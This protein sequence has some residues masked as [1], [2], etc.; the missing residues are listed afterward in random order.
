MRERDV[1]VLHH[2]RKVVGRAFLPEAGKFP[3]VIFSHG[4]NGSGDDFLV[5]ARL[6]AGRGIGAV[7]YDFC[8]GS[9]C[10]KS[11]L[12]SEEMTIFSEKEDLLAVLDE[13]RSW[14][15]VDGKNVFLF[16]AS[17]GGLVTALAAEARPKQVRA[18]VLLYPALCVADDWNR[19]FP[20]T[21]DIPDREELWDMTLGRAFFET[22]RGFSVFERIGVY[23]G[24][25]LI[26][27][28]DADEVVPLAYSETA[29]RLYH[30]AQMEVFPDE[31]HGF[32]PE[33][34][35]MVWQM[36]LGYVLEQM[37]EEKEL[38]DETVEA[39][40]DRMKDSDAYSDFRCTFIPHNCPNCYFNSR[41]ALNPDCYYNDSFDR[42]YREL[43]GDR[44]AKCP[45]F[46]SKTI[47][48]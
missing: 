24:P 34:E 27:H 15:T 12:R 33:G 36:L 26:L 11:D 7:I 3:L 37:N 32:S 48:I 21:D 5:P 25:V 29:Q 6:L 46:K 39:D 28:G 38:S 45:Y 35:E 13:V 22:L 30:N 9:L 44:N 2:G 16:G 20:N 18:M 10:S 40:V 47:E 23:P 42:A 43:K 41:I 4:F 17:M 31:G 19:R 1:A 14:K 8:G